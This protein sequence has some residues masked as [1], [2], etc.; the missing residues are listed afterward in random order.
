[1]CLTDRSSTTLRSQRHA[2]I[3]ECTED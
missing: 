1:M 2:L 3:P